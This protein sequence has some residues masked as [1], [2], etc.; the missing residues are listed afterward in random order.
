M[1]AQ[2]PTTDMLIHEMLERRASRGQVAGLLSRIVREAEQTPQRGGGLRGA[3]QVRSVA[4]TGSLAFV[5]VAVAVAILTVI[6][7]RPV[8]DEPGA[9]PTPIPSPAG[10]SP[11]VLTPSPTPG[12]RTISA[13]GP[14]GPPLEG[15]TWR[16]AS[17][18]PT[19]RFTVPADTWAAGV[20]IPRQLWLQGYLPGAAGDEIEAV[21]LLTVQNV[22]VEPCA[23]GA[24]QTEPWDPALGPAGFLDWIEAE[25]DFDMG[26][27]T[28]LTVLGQEGL[29]VEFIG[30]DLSACE[31][32]FL[33][34]TDNGRSEPYGSPPEG[35]LTRYAAITLLG[36]T[37]LVG[38]WTT[39]PARR[40]IVW[41]AA[42]AVLASIVIE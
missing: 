22:Y 2:I 37:V 8:L 15:G 30:P 16:S 36:Q 32:G 18:E 26:P 25:G 11:T 40:D 12:I 9:T 17:Y 28:P 29:G 24:V 1:T 14:F 3:I 20:D 5:T 23:Q 34:I 21:N 10:P 7:F 41:E 33:A 6:V 19:V 38:T 13:V 42:D 4:R 35:V 27:R 31:G 39:D